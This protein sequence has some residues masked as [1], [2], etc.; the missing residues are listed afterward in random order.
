MVGLKRLVEV[1]KLVLEPDWGWVLTR[2]VELGALGWQGSLV[3]L[4]AVEDEAGQPFVVVLAG[5]VR[6]MIWGGEL[7]QRRLAVEEAGGRRPF[8]KR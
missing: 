7:P 6:W 3:A 4:P 1:P 2:R 8:S 5:L